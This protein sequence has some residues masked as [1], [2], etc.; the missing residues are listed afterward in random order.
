MHCQ[1]SVTGSLLGV[2]QHQICKPV[3]L[4]EILK[5]LLKNTGVKYSSSSA[6]LLTSRTGRAVAQ[7]F[8]S[9]SEGV[10]SFAVC[11]HSG[12]HSWESLSQLEASSDATVMEIIIY[13]STVC[14]RHVNK[15]PFY[16]KDLLAW[17]LNRLAASWSLPAHL[18]LRLFRG[19]W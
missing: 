6:A 5:S 3:F 17:H 2:I 14:L 1:N 7:Y 9:T 8:A 13:L 16:E 11:L 12:Y 18:G 19:G 10:L 4:C 15:F